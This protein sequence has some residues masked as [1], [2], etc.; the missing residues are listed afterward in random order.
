[1]T[2]TAPVLTLIKNVNPGLARRFSIENAF[3]FHDYS[4]A[5]LLQALDWKLKAQDRK[6]TDD[7]KKVAIEVLGRL[8]IRPN[9]GNIGEVENLLSRAKTNYQ[10]RQSSLP[11]HQKDPN[12]PFEPQDFDPDFG[13]DKNAASNLSKLFEDMIGSEDIIDKLGRWQKMAKVLKE[14]G[15]DL[16][17]IPTNFVFKGPPGAIRPTFMEAHADIHTGVGKTTVARK[18]GSVYYDMGILASNEVIECSASDLVGQYIGHT[19]PKTKKLFEKALGRVLF[20][21]EAYRL[22]QGQFAQEAMDE[23][24]GL[25]T[26]DR[27]KG[28]L[29]V[30][31]AGY[32][33]EINNLLQVNTGLS[34]RFPEEIVFQNIM[35]DKCLEILDRKLQKQSVQLPILRDTSSPTY[36]QLVNLVDQL[37]ALPS[38]GNARDME[39]LSK[40]MLEI[41]LSGDST[42]TSA[43]LQLSAQDAL[44]CLNSMLVQRRD[45]IT[46][47]KRRSNRHSEQQ[48]LS[49]G[50]TPPSA[51]P[52][53]QT[54]S[55]TA[56]KPTETDP[57][58]SQ[59]ATTDGI[60]RD[61]GVPDDVWEQLQ[62]DKE[63]AKEEQR[64]AEEKAAEIAEQE[65]K[66]AEEAKRIAN[67]MRRARDNEIKMQELKRRQ[68]AARLRE[69][70]A[71]A[72]REAERKRCEA[73]VRTQTRLRQMGRCVAGF[74]WI[75]QAGGYRCAGGAHFVSDRE[76]GI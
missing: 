44:S 52:S 19:G 47:Q 58:E 53:A 46:N 14:K 35:P 73:E 40:K 63:A 8:R 45:R 69:Q 60:G 38:W 25:L 51:P 68:E 23:L 76:I 59:S 10:D 42:A 55:R 30:I 61:P 22:G 5:E 26:H 54:S 28:K 74:Q 31:L 12:A 16:Q 11:P 20:I 34:S 13:R 24:V 50:P 15:M 36:A 3:H 32:D 72:A 33:Q 43:T 39:T 29:I 9:F 48:A 65:R 18:M 66:A 4:D 70:Q 62:R 1:M 71:R 37:S 64:R 56:T 41:A 49:S 7:A 67:A 27:F 2:A 6:A 57:G 17:N 75:K 21:D